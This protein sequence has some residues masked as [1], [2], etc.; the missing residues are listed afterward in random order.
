MDSKPLALYDFSMISTHILDTSQGMPAA[1]VQVFLE[2]LQDKDWL[3]LADE[4]TNQDGR[5][6]TYRGS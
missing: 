6:S 1:N 4:T 3:E 5:Y 2:Q